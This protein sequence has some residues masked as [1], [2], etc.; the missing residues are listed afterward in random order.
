HGFARLG[1]EEGR[2]VFFVENLEH[3]KLRL[4]TYGLSYREAGE[5]LLLF[6]PGENPVLVRE[7]YQ[8]NHP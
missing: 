6:D 3:E 1:V 7:L 5:H 2:L 8:A 4:A